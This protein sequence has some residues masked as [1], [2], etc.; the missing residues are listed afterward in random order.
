ME[1]RIAGEREKDKEEERG[2]YSLEVNLAGWVI[3][4]ALVIGGSL[5]YFVTNLSRLKLFGLFLVVVGFLATLAISIPLIRL[6]GAKESLAR[7][8]QKV[9]MEQLKEDLKEEEE[10]QQ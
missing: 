1:A 7:E 10:S 8:K 9:K 6:K 2:A 5:L 3:P 4:I